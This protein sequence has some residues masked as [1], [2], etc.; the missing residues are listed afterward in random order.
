MLL[1]EK[2]WTIK[3][4]REESLKMFRERMKIEDKLKFYNKKSLISEENKFTVGEILENDK[5]YIY[6]K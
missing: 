2:A 6:S 1:D 5:I 3:C 4:F